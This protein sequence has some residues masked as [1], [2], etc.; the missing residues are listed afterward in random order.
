MTDNNGAFA[1]YYVIIL[2]AVAGSL[3][4]MRMPVGKMMKMLAAWVAIF[5][6]GFVIGNHNATSATRSLC[7]R[8]HDITH[9]ETCA[10][11]GRWFFRSLGP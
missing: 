7:G 6:I 8:M 2:V 3:V 4:A 10:C 11:R 9:V 5:G 1:L